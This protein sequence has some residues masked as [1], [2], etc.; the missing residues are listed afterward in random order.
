KGQ[1]LLMQRDPRLAE[2]LKAMEDDPYGTLA[3]LMD[4]EIEARSLAAI[5]YDEDTHKLNPFLG[6]NK[7]R[8]VEFMKRDPELAKFYEQEAKPVS[9]PVFGRNKNMIIQ[10]RLYKDPHAA[11]TY[12]IAEQVAQQWLA[13]DKQ[14]PKNSAKQPKRHW[15]SC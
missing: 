4:K 6:D 7:T 15:R 3:T 11:A 12:K 9:I 1:T 2:H 13:S 14:L 8:Q 10:N 5:P